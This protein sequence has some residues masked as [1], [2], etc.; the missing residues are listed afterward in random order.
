MCI[1][2]VGTFMSLILCRGF[3]VIHRFGMGLVKRG[4]GGDNRTHDPLL[5]FVWV[6]V[7]VLET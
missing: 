5:T 2:R 1:A 7:G 6:R 3:S 4:L